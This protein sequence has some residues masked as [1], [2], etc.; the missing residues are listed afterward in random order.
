VVLDVNPRL[1]TSYVGLRQAASSNI[2][3]VTSDKRLVLERATTIRTLDAVNWIAPYLDDSELQQAACR[4]IVELAHHRFLRHP[5]MNVFGP[6]LEKAERVS[7]DPAIVE[8][9]R[10]YRL[11]L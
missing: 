4:A 1:T 11:G 7:D 6:L 2:A 3:E 8:R 5:N 10:R 9:A